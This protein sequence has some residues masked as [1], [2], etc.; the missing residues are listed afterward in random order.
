MAGRRAIAA[1]IAEPAGDIAINPAGVQSRNASKG[2]QQMKKKLMIATVVVFALL[3]GSAVAGSHWLISSTS[4][5]KPS[6]LHKL[7]GAK[8][9]RGA[10]GPAGPAGAQGAAGPSGASTSVIAT[11]QTTVLGSQDLTAANSTVTATC[12]S[13][14]VAVGGSAEAY[15]PNSSGGDPVGFLFQAQSRPSPSGQ[16]QTPT[17][18]TAFL[19]ESNSPDAGPQSDDVTIVAYA[20]CEK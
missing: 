5:I 16:G 20:I 6:V 10:T 17:G 18:W 11:A 14:M 9:P 12:P 19:L 2:E 15:H 3:A 1:G 8:G 13:G 4:Q 7:E